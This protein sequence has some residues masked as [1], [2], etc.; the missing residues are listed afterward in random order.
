MENYWTP[1]F[2]EFYSKLDKFGQKLI[3]LFSVMN[4]ECSKE[5]L[6]VI[7]NEF[8]E[9]DKKMLRDEFERHRIGKIELKF[10][11]ENESEFLN[12][13]LRTLD[14]TLLCDIVINSLR[15]HKIFN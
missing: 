13:R 14:G 1:E 4:Q 15:N 12:D 8:S 11:D 3:L 9:E 2:T 10:F 7:S 5:Y 6:N